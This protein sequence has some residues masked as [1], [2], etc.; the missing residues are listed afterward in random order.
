MSEEM[1]SQNGHKAIHN[2]RKETS[3]LISSED[4]SGV[5][6]ICENEMFGYWFVLKYI[7]RPITW[8]IE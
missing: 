8:K 5:W 4:V 2:S 1:A 6:N 3:W 7:P